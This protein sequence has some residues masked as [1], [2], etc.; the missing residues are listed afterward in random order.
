[1]VEGTFG[2]DGKLE[3]T[4]PSGVTAE[5]LGAVNIKGPDDKKAATDPEADTGRKIVN[6]K[7]TSDL[8]PRV[9]TDPASTHCFET[10]VCCVATVLMPAF[11]HR[12]TGDHH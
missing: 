11:M 8:I 7:V 2:A 3:K 1:M 10:S 6:E 5:G 4:G 9:G 12:L